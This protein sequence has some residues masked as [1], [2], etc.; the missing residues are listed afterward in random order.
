MCP[1]GH[2]TYF[3][4]HNSIPTY[5]RDHPK[6]SIFPPS[7]LPKHNYKSIPHSLS[8]SL[9]SVLPRR[10]PADFVPQLPSKPPQWSWENSVFGRYKK[11][12]KVIMEE[13]FEEDWG[14][15]NIRFASELDREH[16]KSV[17]KKYYWQIREIYRYRAAIG[18]NV[19]EIPFAVPLNTY[20][21]FAKQ[22]N[23][24][25]DKGITVSEIDS[26]FLMIK[27]RY[28]SN[29]LNPNTALIRFQFLEILTRIGMKEHKKGELA[30]TVEKFIV[31]DVLPTHPM[32]TAQEFRDNLYWNVKIDNLY[33]THSIL[34]EEVY[35]KYSGSKCFHGE[36]RFM[37]ISEFEKFVFDSKIQNERFTYKDINLCFSLSM[38]ASIDEVMSSKHL[39]MTY[40]EFLESLARIAHIWSYPPPSDE[41]RD[42]YKTYNSNKDLNLYLENS[43][44]QENKPSVGYQIEEELEI[45]EEECISQ[46]LVNKIE[47][48]LPNILLFCTSN[49]FK[50][51]W[52]WPAKNS[53]FELYEMPTR[54]MT[55]TQKLMQMGVQRLLFSQPGIKNV[56][57]KKMRR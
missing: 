21:E 26:L 46:S 57:Y 44:F 38:Q 35:N 19:G 32:M 47:N 43:K 5:A 54:S 40:V 53:I 6:I 11:D 48:I 23:W 12:E 22:A 1:P 9:P 30:D 37:D 52:V 10:P 13:M 2:I 55:R 8:T 4:S 50:K 31:D 20:Y 15:M 27:N 25:N 29:E 7:P 18:T 49:L 33:K 42:L 14:K 3:F 24:L 36:E 51:Y 17:M 39:Q 28:Q 34:L 45:S 41:F 56:L 16:V